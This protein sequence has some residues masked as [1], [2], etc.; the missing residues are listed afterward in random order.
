MLDQYPTTPGYGE[1]VYIRGLSFYQEANN[2]IHAELED[3]NHAFKVSITHDQQ[4]VTKVT[5]QALRTPFD[6]CNGAL[7]PL[8]QLIGTSLQTSLKDLYAQ[9]NTKQQCTHWIDL[10]FLAISFWQT[11]KAKTHYRITIPDE[12]DSP[13]T[14]TLQE[15]DTIMLEA[16]IKK[17]QIQAPNQHA[18]K[19]LLKGFGAWVSQIEDELEFKLWQIAQKAYFVASARPYD[20]NKLAGE[21]AIKHK[22]VM[23]GACYTYSEPVIH[24]AKRSKNA[25][26]DFS[27]DDTQVLRFT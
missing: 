1:G 6:T 3:C 26:R 20:L 21:P 12:I 14:L 5:G 13:T 27:Q 9:F 4:Q 22:E 18:N 19:P 25:V 24:Q 16:S 11:G 7:E 17:W 10:A 23:L 8:Q 15:N 2:L